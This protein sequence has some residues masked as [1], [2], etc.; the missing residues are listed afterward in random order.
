MPR[1]QPETRVRA[2]QPALVCTHLRMSEV[3]DK[4]EKEKEGERQGGRK[5]SGQ[6]LR[7]DGRASNGGPDTLLK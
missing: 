4:D 2:L 7:E 5:E 3:C 6:A 1:S